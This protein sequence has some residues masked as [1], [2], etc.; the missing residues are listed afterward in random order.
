MELF[1]IGRLPSGNTFEL[2]EDTVENSVRQGSIDHHLVHTKKALQACCVLAKVGDYT[3]GR[4]T[5]EARDEDLNVINHMLDV[6]V[7]FVGLAWAAQLEGLTVKLADGGLP[8]PH[9]AEKLASVP[10][11]DLGIFCRDAPLTGGQAIFDVKLSDEDRLPPTLVGTSLKIVD[12]LWLPARQ[13]LAEN[14][15]K[16]ADVISVNRAA[17]ALM[18]ASGPNSAPRPLSRQAEFNK[19][20]TKHVNDVVTAM[21]LVVPHF[22]P[23]LNISCTHCK[24]TITIP[25]DQ[26]L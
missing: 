11:G 2:V 10:F 1:N 23:V 25:F 19:L 22:E 20:R 5:K 21:D 15:W 14:Q 3:F 26:G 17:A 13:S 12:P 24:K 4:G 7:Q 16:F 6:D 8:C 9:C 18:C